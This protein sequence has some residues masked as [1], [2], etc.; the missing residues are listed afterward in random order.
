MAASGPNFFRSTIRAL[1]RFFFDNG[2]DPLPVRT[3]F[4][5]YNGGKFRADVRAALNVALLALPQGM[6]YAAIAELPIVYGIASS[7]VA[8]II[9][10]IFAGSRHT[11]LGPTNATSL[12]V[13]SFFAASGMATSDKLALMPMLCLMVGMF[14]IFGALLKVAELLQF[15]SR[16][17][18][19]GYIS[20]AATLI[21]A[22]Q[23]KH[24]L[25]IADALDTGGGRSFVHLVLN[26]GRHLAESHWQPLLLGAVT[27]GTFLFLQRKFRS[28]PTFAITLVLASA[29]NWALGNFVPQSGFDAVATFDPFSLSD[30]R[31]TFP[32]TT[33]TSLFDQLSLLTAVAFAIAFLAS[34]ENTVMSKS[35][36]SRTGDRPDINQ[37]MFSVGMA[38]VV[39]SIFAAMPASGS[40]TRSALNYESGARSRLASI[41][42]GLLCLLGVF[43]LAFVPL[44][45]FVPKAALSALVIAIAVSLIN[46][47][48]IRICLRS[49]GDDAA[50]LIIT[51]LA[52]LVAPLHAAIFIGVALSITLF[53]RK[54]S[55]PHLVEY[56]IDDEGDLRELDQKRKRPN[57]AISIVHVEG[58][59]FFGAAELF[60]TQVQRLVVDENL[61]VIILR[62][63]NARHLDATSVMALEDLILSTRSKGRHIIV[64]G[65]GR[66]VYKVLK[67][68]GVLLTLQEG[69][70]R[71]EGQTNLFLNHPSNPNISTRD[72]LLR[73]QELLGTKEADIKIYFD[74]NKDK[75]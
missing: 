60:R 59:L 64:S 42:C 10:P 58:N 16:S 4:R 11:I 23:C 62:L 53:L 67:L 52:T 74:P 1:R 54:A 63:K 18:L 43:F 7:A 14:C 12:M 33:T 48:V 70:K 24:L 36:A 55:T 50:V 49:T 45:A 44:V 5:N 19:V 72:A 35:L 61:Q 17:V 30:L 20:G 69:C 9:A 66:D 32:N 6:A 15:V 68:S 22:N 47:R 39:T 26:I 3:T 31:P 56:E 25:G 8:A 21:I 29:L 57:P 40:L 46:P 51:F 27:L 13:F 73:A 41:M 75:K 2:L 38:N 65:A 37:D 28:L 71:S 34:L